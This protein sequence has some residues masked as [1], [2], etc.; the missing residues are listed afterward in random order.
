MPFG[1]DDNTNYN[2][3][4]DGLERGNATEIVAGLTGGQTGRNIAFWDSVVRDDPQER[5]AAEMD[6][7]CA[8]CCVIL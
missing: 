8:D 7:V 5:K 1:K 3:L 4:F 6:Q 2:L